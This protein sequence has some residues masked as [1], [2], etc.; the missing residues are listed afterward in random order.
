MQEA[1]A[2][3]PRGPAGAAIWPSGGAS[4]SP[5]T[6]G[7]QHGRRG[8]SG[9]EPLPVLFRVQ[10]W[11]RHFCHLCK[12]VTERYITKLEERPS[13]TPLLVIR[14]S[15]GACV[16][17]VGYEIQGILVIKSPGSILHLRINI[18][19]LTAIYVICYSE[20]SRELIVALL[21]ICCHTRK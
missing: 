8:P 5:I 3:V 4:L 6:S 11:L 9:E 2:C 13:H 20:L 18:F 12:L 19:L 17:S 21:K 7:L 16:A 10:S 14:L 1:N 15:N